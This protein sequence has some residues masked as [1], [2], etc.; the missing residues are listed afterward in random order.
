M[1]TKQWTGETSLYILAFL[2]ALGLRFI[3]ANSMPLSDAEAGWALQALSITRGQPVELGPQPGVLLL[4]SLLF[5]I[6]GSSNFLARLIP[7]LAGSLLVFAPATFRGWLGRT[8][9][10]IAAFG[11]AL[12]PGLVALSRQVGSPIPALSFGLLA[13]GAWANRQTILAGLLAGLALLSGP[14][15]LWGLLAIA[16]AWFIGSLLTKLDLAVPW[17][18]SLDSLIFPETASRQLRSGATFVL[19]AVVFIGTLFFRYPQG[20]GS[21]ASILPAY[22][23]G[24]TIP[25][26]VPDLRLPA[27][28]LI[29]APLGLVFGL[30]AAVR[31]WLPVSGLDERQ[32]ALAQR[33]G[34]WALIALIL[35]MA[36]PGRQVSDL[37][38][39]LLPL[40]GLAAVELSLDLAIPKDAYSRLIS[41]G[42]AT[43]LLILA[44]F[45]WMNLAGLSHLAADSGG[46][47]TRGA[48]LLIIGAVSMA[49]VT[50]LLVTLG[51]SWRIARLGLSWGLTIALGIYTLG[52]ITHSAQLRPQA[53]QDLWSQPPEAGQTGLLLTTLED[54]SQWHT[55]FQRQID[56]TVLANSPSL[57]WALRD[58]PR[59][60][61]TTVLSSQDQPS[62]ILAYKDQKTPDLKSGYR[63]EAFTWER[64]P[65][66]EG[67]LPPDLP[68]WLVFRQAPTQDSQVILWARLDLFPGG[69]TSSQGAPSSTP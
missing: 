54:L 49:A 24:W 33:L 64:Y 41:L 40:W 14:A 19:A 63:G 57:Q 18:T 38:W 32:R 22:L 62:V 27:A 2:L 6:F 48:L 52:N 9:A 55:G 69:A 29:Y 5:S 16:L 28:L 58:F 46:T 47:G 3:Y 35:F 1:K 66:W 30:I 56:V 65:G 26:G 39:V 20:L 10:L 8:A 34:L 59:A 23:Q 43:L 51:W 42:Q 4:T 15:I 21:L 7:A 36:Y 17:V 44:A 13:L 60:Q 61:F 12:D 37:A 50:T 53:S 25:S 68:A 31:S 45:A 67:L 11:L